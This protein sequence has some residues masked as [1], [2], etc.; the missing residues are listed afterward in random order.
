M[1]YYYVLNQE[2]VSSKILISIPS[3]VISLNITSVTLKIFVMSTPMFISQ[4][5]VVCSYVL[6]ITQYLVNI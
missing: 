4:E 2:C 3:L 6:Y 5:S 1:L